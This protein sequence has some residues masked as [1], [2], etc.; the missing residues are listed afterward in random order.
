MSMAIEDQLSS[1]S[2]ARDSMARILAMAGHD[3]RQPLNVALLNLERATVGALSERSADQLRIAMDALHRLNS[4][5]KDL[6]RV[7]QLGQTPGSLQ[8]IDMSAVMEQL[9]SDWAQYAGLCGIALITTRPGISVVSDPMLLRSILRNLVGNAI[10]YSA[11]GDHVVVDCIADDGL[12]TVIVRDEGCGIAHDH[13]ERMFGAFVRGD[14]AGT[15][16]G[17]GLGLTI[18][19][20]MASTLGHRVTVESEQGV[21]STFALELPLAVRQQL[22]LPA[23]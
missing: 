14:A 11:R 10:R 17:L 18:V 1:T 16:D 9:D 20:E 3:L 21:G 22:L 19:R 12:A 4:E 8:N 6:A 15:Q 2:A 5:L 13:I 7:S 23:R